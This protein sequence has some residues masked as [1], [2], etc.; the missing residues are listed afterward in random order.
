M[1]CKGIARKEYRQ[2]KS[3]IFMGLL[4]IFVLKISNLAD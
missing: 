3:P 1:D 2:T 4:I